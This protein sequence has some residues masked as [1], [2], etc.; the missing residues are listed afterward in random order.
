MRSLARYA[1]ANAKTRARLGKLLSREE[2]ERL[3][4]A[5]EISGF[6]DVLR[7]TV[8]RDLV[9]DTRSEEDLP[10]LELLLWG[11]EMNSCKEVYRDLRGIPGKFAEILLEKYEIQQLLIVLRMKFDNREFDRNCIIPRLEVLHPLPLEKILE[12]TSLEQAILYLERTPYR[13]P[14]VKGWEGFKK[15][16]AF[17]FLEWS[18]EKDHYIKLG[19]IADKL[20]NN[21]KKIVKRL[22]GL[23]VDLLNIARVIRFKKYYQISA[24]E[25]AEF[26][27]PYGWQVRRQVLVESF[28]EGDAS[29]LLKE[30]KKGPAGQLASFAEGTNR[31]GT[32]LILESVLWRLMAQEARSALMKFPFTIGTEI[33]YLNLMR[34]EIRN[35]K[36]I[37]GIKSRNVDKD[38]LGELVI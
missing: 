2:Y 1:S 8:Y 37:L 34:I 18:L 19:E 16:G 11:K 6:L 30:L 25:I 7:G 5:N 27:L 20:S 14:L 10:E 31:K 36:I 21:D 28:L 15:T 13:E 17:F 23:E 29:S 26:L 4:S 32:L 24:G 33:A 3:S 22:I 38:I 9:K 35:L 12:S